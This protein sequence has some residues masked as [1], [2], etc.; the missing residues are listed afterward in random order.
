MGRPWHS[1]GQFVSPVDGSVLL[2]VTCWCEHRVLR[3]PAEMVARRRDREL[4]PLDL[5]ATC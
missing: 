5:Q 2:D 1:T 4:W 3:V